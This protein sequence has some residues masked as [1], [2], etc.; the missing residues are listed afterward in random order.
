MI[1]AAC[2]RAGTDVGHLGEA[3]ASGLVRIDANRVSFTHPLI[4]GVVYQ[5]GEAAERRIAHAALA[6]ALGDDDD[7]R[8]W[9]LAAAAI[10]T[11]EE[12]AASLERVGSQAVARRAYAAG[13]GALERA[14]GLTPARKAATRRLIAAG[15]AAA[16]AGTADRA[17]DLFGKAADIAGTEDQR[18]QVQQL[19]GRVMLWLGQGADALPLLVEQAGLAAP[20]AAGA[21][22]GD[23][24]GR[25]QRRHHDRFLPGG[26]EAGLARGRATP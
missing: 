10:G 18:A 1:A 21:G 9:H 2:L 4:R 24:L 15:Q 12:V 23:V 16:G 25:G 14:A 17:L 6:A 20:Q 26:G 22:G 5:E 3:E 8:V 7:R 19:R 11:D 13:S